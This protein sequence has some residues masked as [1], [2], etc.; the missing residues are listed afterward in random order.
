MG[1]KT[2]T[3]IDARVPWRA[4]FAEHS[5]LFEP[6]N[7]WARHFSG[8]D[9]W[10]ELADYQHL[11]DSLP[12]PIRLQ[13]GKPLRIVSQDGRPA[14]FEQHYAPRMYLT[15]EIQTR[16]NNWHDF[17]QYL[18]WFVFPK[19]KAAINALHIPRAQ[20]RIAGGGELGRRSPLENM[21]SLF[22]EGGAVLLSSDEELLNL[23]REFRWKELFWQRRAEVEEKLQC[24]TFGHAMYEKALAPY[25]GMTANCIL[26]YV[27]EPFLRLSLPERLRW[28]DAH[29]AALLQRGLEYREPQ[30]L[31]PFPIL[32]MPGWDVANAVESY[33]D[34]TGYFRPGR[35]RQPGLSSIT[36]RDFSATPR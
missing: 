12:E 18:T 11:L 31:Q 16:R 26:L 35:R 10:P 1:V 9:Q 21:L 29:L 7:T 6:I 30:D 24:L 33:Y 3:E 25:V 19:T 15:G 17:F 27:E 23:I 14:Q 8:Y 4:D 2:N 20:A 36:T 34:N 13:S 32:G 5:P 22:D 28:L